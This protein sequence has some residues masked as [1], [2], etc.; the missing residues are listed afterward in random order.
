M[1]RIYP[2]EKATVKPSELPDDIVLS[3]GKLV[4]AC[5]EME[6]ILDLFICGLAE[7][8]ESKAT[9]LLGRT[10]VTRRVEI[11]LEL[12]KLRTD[13]A[14]TVHKKAFDSAFDDILYCRNV[15]SHGTFMGTSE[16][17]YVFRTAL[18]GPTLTDQKLR[19]AV[20]LPA[21]TIHDT[22]ALATLRAAELEEFLQVKEQR[23]ERQT[24]S[25]SP[26]NKSQPLASAKRPPPPQSSRG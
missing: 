16:H 11:A 13:E 20:A 24:Q 19:L 8:S 21:Q 10:A 12:A 9:I 3:I 17:G 26:H 18:P 25:L 22:A 23:A 6:D 2:S 15:V 5:A 14:V 4:R 7:I 1:A